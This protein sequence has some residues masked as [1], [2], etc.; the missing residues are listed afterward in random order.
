MSELKEVKVIT[1]IPGPKSKEMFDIRLKNV[2]GGVS[3]QHMGVIK[4]GEGALFEDVDGN[5]MLDFAGGIGVLNIGYS[6]PEVVKAAK[7]QCDKFFHSMIN[8]IGYE[9]YF[10][11]TD[12]LNNLVPGNFEKKTMLVNSGSEANENAVKIARK[13]TGRPEIV[14]FTG[15]FHGRTN[16][17]MAMTSKVK[18]YKLGFGPFAPNISQVPFPYCYRCPYGQE[19]GTCDM[20]CAKQWDNFFAERVA[21]EDIA[22]IIIEPQQGEGGFVVPPIEYVAELRKICDEHGIVL[23]ADEVQTGFCRTGKMFATDYWSE[24]GIYPDI[25]TSAKSMA[26]GL[27]ISAVTAKSEIIDASQA[28]GI[29]GTFAGNPIAAA[30]ALK[31]LEIMERDDLASR[32]CQI[33][34]IVNSRLKA[35]QEK[36]EIIGDVRGLGSMVGIEFVKDR[37]T[38]EP[39]KDITSK[40]VEEC[41]KTGLVILNAGVRGNVIRFLMPLVITDDL[42]ESG[43]DILEAAICKVTQ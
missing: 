21:A 31:V 36:Y 13:Y 29:G 43:L 18:P 2:P 39:A 33:G 37:V 19:K 9:Q 12:K 41:G 34:E 27:P 16:L 20:F 11:L 1:D 25:L 22:A 6:H 38:K 17:T 24:K 10:T 8:I 14:C 42:L 35:M 40:I 7:E 30:A 32:S 4:R 26:G 28:G 15:A 23:I 3:Y 5:V